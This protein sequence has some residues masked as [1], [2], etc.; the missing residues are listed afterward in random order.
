MAA[1]DGRAPWDD[2]TQLLDELTLYDRSLLK[3]SRLV[4]A[5]KMDEPVAESN[6]RKFKRRV[7]RTPVIPISA[8][9]GDGLDRLRK[10]M[11]SAAEEAF[12]ADSDPSSQRF[13]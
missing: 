1:T 3:R 9:F 6:L 2:Y 4:V 7:P 13:P 5:N 11:R 8:A 12:Q 10:G